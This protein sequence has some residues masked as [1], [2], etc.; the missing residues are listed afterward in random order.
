MFRQKQG[1]GRRD[2]R[3]QDSEHCALCV[4]QIAS[5]FWITPVPVFYS[6]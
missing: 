1:Q 4:Q 2:K 6:R 5:M 3:L